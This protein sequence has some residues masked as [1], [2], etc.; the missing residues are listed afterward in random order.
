M[1]F[2]GNPQVAPA[3]SPVLLITRAVLLETM[4]R[5]D[6]YALFIFMALFLLG[7]LI[8][9][10][11][12]IPNA[13]TATFLVNLGLSMAFLFAKILTLLVATRQIPDECEAR[14]IHPLLAKPVRRWQYLLGKWFAA[15]LSGTIALSI[16]FLMGWAPIPHLETF[17]AVTLLQ[18]LLLQIVSLG[19]VASLG[20]LFSLLMPKI[21]SVVLL[22]IVIFEGD[23]IAGFIRARSLGSTFGSVC[24]WVAGYVPDFNHLDLTRLYTDGLPPLGPTDLLLRLGYGVGLTF[25]YLVI[26]NAVFSRRSL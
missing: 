8:T 18:T 3:P 16:L 15:T 4:R 19:F 2:S 22:A 17:N 10:V 9:L 1:S 13:A 23:S 6:F 5:R 14:T 24:R 21:M 25:V 12:G 20:L 11:V 26:A 7:A